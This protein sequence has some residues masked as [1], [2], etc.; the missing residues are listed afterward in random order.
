MKQNGWVRRL[1]YIT[2]LL[3]QELLLES[4]QVCL[5]G[6]TRHP[7]QAWMEQHVTSLIQM[8]RNAADESL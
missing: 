1:T 5:A 7:D 3:N 6:I 8:A 4:R 2:G